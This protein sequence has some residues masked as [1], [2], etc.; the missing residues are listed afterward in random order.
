MKKK[1]WNPSKGVFVNRKNEFSQLDLKFIRFTSKILI[2]FGFLNSE[3]VKHIFDNL[4]GVRKTAYTRTNIIKWL[5]EIK[6]IKLEIIAEQEL[7]FIRKP[8]FNESFRFGKTFEKYLTKSRNP[9]ACW[10]IEG[11]KKECR[12]V[13]T[14]DLVVKYLQKNILKGPGWV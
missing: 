8:K 7:P 3:N 9:C 5:N 6:K 14:I 4:N 2:L 1:V 12:C 10:L 13:Q 11:E